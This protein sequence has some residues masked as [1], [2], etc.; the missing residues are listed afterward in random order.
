MD[1]IAYVAPSIAAAS[2]VQLVLALIAFVIV[3]W[4]LKWL[5]R[6]IDF[7]FKGWISNANDN[8]VS[9][10]LGYRILAVCILV[11]LIVSGSL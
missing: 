2:V 8:A 1:Q 7:D 6:I 11:G 9:N 10:Y 3:R 4:V 5:D